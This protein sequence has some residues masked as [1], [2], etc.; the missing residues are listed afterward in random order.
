[1]TPRL[2]IPALFS[3]AFATEL[4]A[5]DQAEAAKTDPVTSPWDANA[6]EAGSARVFWRAGI[7]KAKAPASGKTIPF[8]SA[9]TPSPAAPLNRV[10]AKSDLSNRQ[11]EK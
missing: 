1:M 9:A 3:V 8:G 2:V 7:V 4:F 5:S 10:P 6:W 11:S